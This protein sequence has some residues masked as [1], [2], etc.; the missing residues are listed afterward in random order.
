LF[1]QVEFKTEGVYYI[2]VLVDDV[3][4]I[5]YPVPLVVA[6]PQ[7]QQAGQPPKSESGG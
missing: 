6:P 7:Q 3:M 5:R 4:K 2:E 1:G